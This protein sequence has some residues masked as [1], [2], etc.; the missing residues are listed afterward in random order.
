MMIQFYFPEQMKRAQALIFI[1]P[2][3]HPFPLF[4]LSATPSYLSNNATYA[5][6]DAC[7]TEPFPCVVNDSSNAIWLGSAWLGL[8][9]PFFVALPGLVWLGLSCLVLSL[10]VLAWV[11][12]ALPALGLRL[13]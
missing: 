11:D 9:L 2:P 10:L 12:L 1:F 8:D 7:W 6:I 5:D 4:S 3:P 13:A